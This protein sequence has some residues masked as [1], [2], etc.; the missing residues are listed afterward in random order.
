MIYLWKGE[1]SISFPRGTRWKTEILMD[2]M[3]FIFCFWL[4]ARVDSLT[5]DIILERGRVLRLLVLSNVIG[6]TAT[7]IVT[8]ING[9]K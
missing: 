3:S 7:L 6:P 4:M 2:K 8:R 5:D 9:A 1:N